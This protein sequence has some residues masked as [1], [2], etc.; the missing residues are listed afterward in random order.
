MRGLPA[1]C[2][3]NQGW[4]ELSLVAVNRRNNSALVEQIPT[5]SGAPW[6]Y[7]PTGNAACERRRGWCGVIG[8][9]YTSPRKR[10]GMGGW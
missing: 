9:L 4:A 7:T 1:L 8:L 10:T 5:F 6:R 2:H 3:A